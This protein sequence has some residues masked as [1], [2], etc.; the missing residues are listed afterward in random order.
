MDLEPCYDF[1]APNKS[2]LL[3]SNKPCTCRTKQGEAHGQADIMLDFLPRSKINIKAEYPTSD[4][5]VLYSGISDDPRL[6]I[7]GLELKT[8]LTKVNLSTSSPTCQM[9]CRPQRQP[10]LWTGDD[11]TKI[12]KVVFHL[13]N[14]KDTLGT[15]R[16]FRKTGDKTIGCLETKIESEEWILELH[17]N[18]M[19]E[20]IKQLRETG[21][22]GLTHIGCFYRADGSQY[23]GETAMKMLEHLHH[24]FTFSKGTF[25]STVLP[26]GF[27]ESEHRVWELLNSP[28][29]PWS[30]PISWFDP[31]HCEQ[32]V[33]LFPGF[34]EKLENKNW[35]DTL[36]QVLYWYA[37][38]NDTSGSGIDT[39][40]ILTQIAIERLAYEYSVNHKKMI[41]SE[42]FKKLKA[43]NK[44]R[45]LFSSLEIPMEIPEKLTEI[46]R[47]A[48]K[49]GYGD[50]PYVLTL[51]R[52]SLVHP[53]KNRANELKDAYYEAWALGLWYLELTILRIC[54]YQGTYFNRLSGELWVG[55][56]ENVPWLNS[57]CEV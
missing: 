27:N 6:W 11:N 18:N 43:S 22:Y 40:I 53:E 23:D 10:I 35:K 17:N 37:R 36:H 15:H 28:R 12:S 33:N 8:F 34:I 1:K 30:N 14:Y 9:E 2:V 56:V 57:Q 29:E 5:T 7:N 45:L 48:K 41:D 32:L 44:F 20:C 42:D 4:F 46:H 21:G 13:F 25:C 24:L 47:V 54:N 19:Y 3:A 51:I 55:N 16:S 38:S 52:N 31:H 49:F 50:A 26:V 39:G